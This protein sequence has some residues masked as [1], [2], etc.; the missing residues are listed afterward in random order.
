MTSFC[1]A[2]CRYAI[3]ASWK[4]RNDRFWSIAL[5]SLRWLCCWARCSTLQ[6]MDNM[7]A[8]WVFYVKDGTFNHLEQSK[9]SPLNVNKLG[10]VRLTIQ[11]DL[12]VSVSFMSYPEENLRQTS[13]DI[14]SL[15]QWPIYIWQSCHF[16][17]RTM[18]F[19]AVYKHNIRPTYF[20]LRGGGE[21]LPL[22]PIC[23]R[24]H[25]EYNKYIGC[26]LSHSDMMLNI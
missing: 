1:S 13:A 15:E 22:A 11:H 3:C 10:I 12:I 4:W 25:R 17:C 19:I 21:P 8:S 14:L 9:I 6:G 2:L 18:H 5:C 20:K 7:E 26:Y 16:G 24:I 23:S